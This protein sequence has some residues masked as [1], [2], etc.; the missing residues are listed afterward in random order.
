MSQL[1]KALGRAKIEFIRSINFVKILAFAIFAINLS[2]CATVDLN[3]VAAPQ[4]AGAEQLPQKNIVRRTSEDLSANF[5]SRAFVTKAVN[6]GS[7]SAANV[8]LFG[9][10]DKQDFQSVNL[11]LE[12]AK[13]IE[14]V[15]KDVKFARDQVIKT[16]TAS[17]IFLE[18]S[19]YDDDL[20]QELASLETAL[21]TSRQAYQTFETALNGQGVDA[22]N[23]LDQSLLELRDITNAYGQ[24]VRS[25][26]KIRNNGVEHIAL[27]IG[28]DSAYQSQ[29]PSQTADKFV[30]F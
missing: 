14:N 13:P 1:L 26:D 29:N 11:Y 30:S 27:F 15:L 21:I 19:S 25:Q 7:Q 28:R 20:R 12:Q 23:A 16:V 6:N 22:L 4:Q 8:L 2:A 10:K 17:K 3:D 24:H 9:L 5:N 18:V